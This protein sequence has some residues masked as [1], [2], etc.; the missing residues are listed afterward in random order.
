[1]D[2]LVLI[3]KNAKSCS[4]S[5]VENLITF[6]FAFSL[7]YKLSILLDA[8]SCL[9]CA[10]HLKS[11]DE[12]KRTK[13]MLNYV[14]LLKVLLVI[15]GKSKLDETYRWEKSNK[16]VHSTK[17]LLISGRQTFYHFNVSHFASN[18]LKSVSENS[19][20]VTVFIRLHCHISLSYS[21]GTLNLNLIAYMHTGEYKLQRW[22]ICTFR[23]EWKLHQYLNA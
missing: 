18:V 9:I 1:M 20:K 16:N 11:S 7:F 3:H 10:F 12:E 22:N 14:T 19:W 2:N 17:K 6:N 5:K 23:S 15:A 4:S 8:C 21:I 13:R